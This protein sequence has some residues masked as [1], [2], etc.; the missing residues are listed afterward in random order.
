MFSFF[1]SLSFSS[2]GSRNSSS[3]SFWTIR[4]LKMSF[5]L[6]NLFYFSNFPFHLIPN[7]SYAWTQICFYS[8][9][10]VFFFFVIPKQSVMWLYFVYAV[11][12]H[13]CFTVHA[14]PQHHTYREMNGFRKTKKKLN[15]WQL[16]IL[17]HP[18]NIILLIEYSLEQNNI[19]L[20]KLHSIW[21]CACVC[22]SGY[23]CVLFIWPKIEN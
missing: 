12:G 7:L 22:L 13:G 20:Y 3:S 11:D 1:F 2:S 10:T 14:H 15:R 23:V 5:L 17:F 18:V 8:L 16:P 21:L 6:N 9:K 19:L 4:L